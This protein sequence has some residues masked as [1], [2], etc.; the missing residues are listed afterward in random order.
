MTPSGRRRPRE[1]RAGRPAAGSIRAERGAALLTAMLIVTLVVTLTSAMVWQQWRAVQVE[2]AERARTQSAWILTGA[3]D[4]AKLILRENLRSNPNLDHLGQ[5]WAVPLAE[6][7]LSTFLAADKDNHSDDGPEAFLSGS[8]TDA[9]ARFN[10]TNLV[11][12]GQPDAGELAALTRLCGTLGLDAA[13][14]SRIATGMQSATTSQ[15]T[16]SGAGG[17]SGTVATAGAATTSTATA[18]ATAASSVPGTTSTSTSTSTGTA[19]GS[20]TTTVAT[21]V[22]ST[23]PVPLLPRSVE[24]LAWL[25]IDAQALE[26]LAPYLAVLPVGTSLNV[27]TASREM[28]A[29]EFNIDLG[30]AERLV[31]LRQRTPFK[32]ANDFIAQLPSPPAA[33]AKIAVAS[34]FFEVRGRLR[35]GDRLLE[36]RSLLQRLQGGQVNVIGSERVPGRDD[37]ATS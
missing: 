37:R 30:S 7:R 23:G 26:V 14:A 1:T 10:V 34:S 21:A 4:W 32:T 8:I 36:E 12:V 31:Q 22:A 27:N 33:N 3:L 17:S 24:Q 9:Q 13:I 29:A 28:L 19:A 25:G 6:S 35:L 16:A 5:P 18:T 11:G 15:T 2:V 20:G